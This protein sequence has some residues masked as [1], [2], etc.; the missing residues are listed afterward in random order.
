ME[1]RT[2]LLTQ[3]WLPFLMNICLVST[4]VLYGS[5]LEPVRCAETFGQ[6]FQ[7]G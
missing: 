3:V 4:V 5:F 1:M 7:L 2:F 6:Q